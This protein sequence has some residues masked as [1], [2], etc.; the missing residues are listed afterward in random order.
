MAITF[1]QADKLY[2]WQISAVRVND[3]LKPSSKLRV[4]MC[5]FLPWP[6]SSPAAHFGK[7]SVVAIAPAVV[8]KSLRVW[9]MIYLRTASGSANQFSIVAWGTL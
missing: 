6:C 2:F 1:K 3:F 8:M 4:T 5:R 9:L 7:A